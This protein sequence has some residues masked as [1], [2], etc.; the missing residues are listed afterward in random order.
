VAGIDP[1]WSGALPA[2]FLYDKTGR[3]VRAF[4][5]EVSIA[6]LEAAIKKLL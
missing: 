1:K 3:K 4:F 5:G 2:S 6:E